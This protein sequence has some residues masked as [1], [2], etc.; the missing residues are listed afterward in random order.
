MRCIVNLA[1]KTDRSLTQVPL[2]T[3]VS[4]SVMD[5]NI[6]RM[7]ENWSTDIEPVKSPASC[8]YTD[9]PHLPAQAVLMQQTVSMAIQPT[10]SRGP[11]IAGDPLPLCQ[12]DQWTINIE[13]GRFAS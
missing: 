4:E 12:T 11:A 2:G 5:G 1:L 9:Q 6:S 13:M 8:Q 7:C 10:F 3:W